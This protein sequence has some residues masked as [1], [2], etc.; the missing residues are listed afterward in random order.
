MGARATRGRALGHA[1]PQELPPPDRQ[2]LLNR[3]LVDPE[4]ELA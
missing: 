4:T 1:L 2:A 3:L